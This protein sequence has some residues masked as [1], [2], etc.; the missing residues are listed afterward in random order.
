MNV[1]I[2]EITSGL[3]FLSVLND[4]MEDLS[5]LTKEDI[6]LINT[7][8]KL[9][10]TKWNECFII[11]ALSL[12]Q[13]YINDFD[14]LS[15]LN[16]NFSILEKYISK[17]KVSFDGKHIIFSSDNN[18]C[19][20]DIIGSPVSIENDSYYYQTDDIDFSDI[21]NSN[22]NDEYQFDKNVLKYVNLQF[23]LHNVNIKNLF[24][25][26]CFNL[27]KEPMEFQK[28]GI[29]FGL[30][31]KK[32]ILADDMGL[33][34]SLQ[35]LII[36]EKSKKLPCLIVCPNSLKLNWQKEIRETLGKESIILRKQKGKNEDTDIESDFYI[37]NYES[38]HNF[39]NFIV[40][41]NIQI[42]IFDES[43]FIKNYKAKRTQTCLNLS[44]QAE[45]IIALTG[46]PILNRPHEL[47]TQLDLIGKLDDLGG[48]WGYSQEFCNSK[49]EEWGWDN[50][51]SSNLTKLS[52]KLRESCL[53]RREKTEVLKDLP[54]KR[55][56]II[57]IEISN[58]KDYEKKLKEFNLTPKT[59]KSKRATLFHECN[60]LSA[61]GKMNELKSFVDEFIFSNEKVVIFAK[62]KKILKKLQDIFPDSLRIM[63]EDNVDVR[64]YNSVEFQK[65]KEKKIIICGLDV[66]YFGFD[67]F[68][69]SN[70]IFTEFDYVDEKNKQAEDRLCRIGQR[71]SVNAW[72]L[73]ADKTNDERILKITRTKK[74]IT[75]DVKNGF[76]TELLDKI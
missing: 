27:K 41:K 51:G 3:E 58:F 9:P 31:N 4:E 8:L 26:N 49:E 37:V 65:N 16:L 33:G 7:L 19:F 55:R 42:M 17:T 23:N 12:I 18:K 6:S 5:F 64:F 68:A 21:I 47:V 74:D 61:L 28:Y 54:E 70:V 56:S 72:Y 75:D 52:I 62:H 14:E 59:E 60:I 73:V 32:I 39:K 50:S 46:T 48:F 67:L 22:K 29:A 45:Y 34:K 15:S 53:I 71:N 20:K 63:E 38:L 40:N 13:I 69:S 25:D 10:Y 44:K 30:L 1:D 66:A 2:T 36:A 11:K 43:H 35:A 76:K 24:S 57:P